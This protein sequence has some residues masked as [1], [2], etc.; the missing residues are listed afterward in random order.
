MLLCQS[1]QKSRATYHT[2]VIDLGGQFSRI[3]PV[4]PGRSTKIEVCEHPTTMVETGTPR[5][6]RGCSQVRVNWTIYG[7]TKLEGRARSPSCLKIGD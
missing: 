7:H 3:V 6:F 2:C 4:R 1:T 5:V